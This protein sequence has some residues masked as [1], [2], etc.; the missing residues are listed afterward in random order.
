MTNV[1][2]HPLTTTQEAE[3]FSQLG[4]LFSKR[5]PQQ[6][7]ELFDDLLSQTEKIMLAKRLAILVMLYK[8]QSLYFIAQTLHV[9]SATVARLQECLEHDQFDHILKTLEKPTPAILEIIQAID[10]IL[11]LGGIL[12]HYGQSHA[13]EAYKKNQEARRKNLSVN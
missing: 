3:L 11:H 9:S 2:K 5:N 4:V 7:Q 8:K 1:S 12:P 10:D 6:A 13:S